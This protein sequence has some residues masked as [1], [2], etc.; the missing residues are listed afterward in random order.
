MVTTN[1][2]AGPPLTAR[3]LSVRIGRAEP[4]GPKGEPSAIRKR[5]V[6]GRLLLSRLGLAGDEQADRRH[7]G[8]PDKA[9]HHYPLEHYAT[10]RRV[11]P[12]RTPFLEAS[13]FGENLLLGTE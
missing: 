11:F 10:W 7:H 2:S 3:L 5:P 13:G 4:F 8:G 9:L 12:E 1:A 6:A